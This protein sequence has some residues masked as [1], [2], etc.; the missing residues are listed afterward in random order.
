MYGQQN[1]NAMCKNSEQL[2]IFLFE[3][4][5][6]INIYILRPVLTKAKY[7]FTT[8]SACLS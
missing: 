5:I 1:R 2:L 7:I 6:D 3:L 4:Y 8:M